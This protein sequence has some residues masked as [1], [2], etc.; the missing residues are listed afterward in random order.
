MNVDH[1]ANHAPQTVAKRAMTATGEKHVMK[2]VHKSV[3]RVEN[4][5]G[6]VYPVNLDTTFIIANAPPVYVTQ[7]GVHPV[8]TDTGEVHV[9]ETVRKTV[10]C[11][12][13]LM[14]IVCPVILDTTCI[15]A[16][17]PLV[18]RTVQYVAKEGVL[19]VMTDTGEGHVMK[20][21]RKIVLCA[22][23]RTVIAC[24]VLLDTTFIIANVPIVV[25]TVQHVAPEGVYPV[26]TDTGEVHVI[27]TVRKT[28]LRVV[29]RMA[30]VYPVDL[31]TI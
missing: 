6:I 13:N 30:I 5:M 25:H 2:T 9:M 16:N 1:N 28:V 24:P 19:P 31:D 4:R 8:M 29:N 18:V 10:R 3:L 17:V 27:K 15:M 11:V 23:N 7:E 22:V 12:V 21:V 14:V 20:T 26:M